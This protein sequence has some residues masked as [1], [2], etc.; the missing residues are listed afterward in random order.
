MVRKHGGAD[1]GANQMVEAQGGDEPPGE[2]PRFLQIS[3]VKGRETRAGVSLRG[4]REDGGAQSMAGNS[5][6][7]RVGGAA[8]GGCRRSGVCVRV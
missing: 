3:R 6:L 1:K 8:R 5:V 2:Q 4:R 7:R